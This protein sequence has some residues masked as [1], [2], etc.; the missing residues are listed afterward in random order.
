[1]NETFAITVNEFGK[2]RELPAYA[3]GHCSKTVLIN[4][5]RVRPRVACSKCGRWICESNQLCATDCTPIYDLANDR[6][7]TVP[8]KWSK[9]VP[10]IMAGETNLQVAE[11]K[12]LII[13]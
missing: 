8:S 11:S 10:A 2:A 9:L 4:P 6:T 12:G 7:W 5:L 1:M 3:C 13:P